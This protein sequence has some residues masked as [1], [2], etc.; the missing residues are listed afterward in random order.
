MDNGVMGHYPPTSPLTTI[1]TEAI[2]YDEAKPGQAFLKPGIGLLR[3]V[4]ERPYNSGGLYPIVD[5]GTWTT[6]IKKDSIVFQQV[7]KGFLKVMP[8]CIPKHSPS[9]RMARE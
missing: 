8:M 7:L 4:D 2:G 1:H 6:R 9:T 3:R 5:G